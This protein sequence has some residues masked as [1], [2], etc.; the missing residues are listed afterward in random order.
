MIHEE[1]NEIVK[2]QSP[3]D[4]TII[5]YNINSRSITSYEYSRNRKGESDS[6]KNN[7]SEKD[8]YFENRTQRSRVEE[9]EDTSG[10][11]REKTDS[12]IKGNEGYSESVHKKNDSDNNFLSNW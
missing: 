7:D 2:I 8:E 10:E 9:M 5:Y 11:E 12:G 4:K 3:T 1:N 6:E